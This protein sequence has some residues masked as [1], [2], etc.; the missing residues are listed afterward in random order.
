[1]KSKSIQIRKMTFPLPPM[2]SN[3]WK[4]GGG[5][6]AVLDRKLKMSPNVKHNTSLGVDQGFIFK[7]TK[8]WTPEILLE[9]YFVHKKWTVYKAKKYIFKKEKSERIRKK[10]PST[11]CIFHILR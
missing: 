9:C 6:G 8:P 2:D 3:S 5:G 11:K 7:L 4:R 1:M 10:I